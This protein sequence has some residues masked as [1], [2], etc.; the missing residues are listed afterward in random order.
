MHYKVHIDYK[1]NAVSVIHH[2]DH[3]S[4]DIYIRRKYR[5]KNL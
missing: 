4:F 3:Q 1:I 2:I 5:Q